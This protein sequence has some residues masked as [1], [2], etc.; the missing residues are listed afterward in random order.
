MLKIKKKQLDSKSHS[1][2]KMI[3]K[4]TLKFIKN[5]QNERKIV[6]LKANFH[7]TN[8]YNGASSGFEI[9]INNKSE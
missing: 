8:V 9:Y 1:T 3:R 2:V 5:L 4:I 7:P 6:Q